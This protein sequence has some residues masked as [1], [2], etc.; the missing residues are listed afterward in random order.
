MARILVID[1]DASIRRSVR[2]MLERT[3]HQI[4]E[5]ADGEAGIRELRR[6]PVQ[7]VLTDIYMPGED[8]FATMRRLRRE[9]PGIKIITMSGGSRAG[10]A[11]LSASAAAMGAA[12]TLNKPFS[13]EDLLGIVKRVLGHGTETPDA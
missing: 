11:D 4:V 13:M 9:W 5:A 3:G 8:G 6:Q 12:G 2:R 7:L 1:D 10:P